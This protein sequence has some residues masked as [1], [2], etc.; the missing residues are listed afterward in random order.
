MSC[1]RPICP[2][3][4]PPV[5][6]PAQALQRT[7][8]L[9]V[10]RTPRVHVPPNINNTGTALA[11]DSLRRHL[12]A[13]VPLIAGKRYWA[14]LQKIGDTTRLVNYR[15]GRRF[16]EIETHQTRQHFSSL[17]LSSFGEKPTEVLTEFPVNAQ[18]G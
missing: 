9:S 7:P 6:L 3:V 14:L 4:C 10:T 15:E 17:Q 13:K 2:G 8:K 11:Y 1:E 5:I 12:A 18:L 16:L